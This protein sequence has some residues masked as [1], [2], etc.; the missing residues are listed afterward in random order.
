MPKIGHGVADGAA[1]SLLT[2]K[3]GAVVAADIPVGT[4][5]IVKDTSGGSVKLVYNDAGTLKSVTLT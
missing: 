3:A 2:K 1:K 5:R 4:F